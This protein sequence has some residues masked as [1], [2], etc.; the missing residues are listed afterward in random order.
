[1]HFT[2]V[3]CSPTRQTPSL[4]RQKARRRPPGEEVFSSPS[5]ISRESAVPQ[6][7]LAGLRP[8]ASGIDANGGQRPVWERNPSGELQSCF[9]WTL[10]GPVS[11]RGSP[12]AAAKVAAS[13]VGGRPTTA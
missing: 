2:W 9:P 10:D 4:L 6:T 5:R 13:W 8:P 7:G 12:C 1:V 3:P 11:C